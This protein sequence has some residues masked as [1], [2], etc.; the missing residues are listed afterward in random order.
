MPRKEYEERIDTLMTDQNTGS[1]PLPGNLAKMDRATTPRL[2]PTQV[3]YATHWVGDSDFPE[4]TIVG[5]FIA[6][7]A[8]FEMTLSYTMPDGTLEGSVHYESARRALEPYAEQLRHR[9]EGAGSALNWDSGTT[10][11]IKVDGF[12]MAGRA[13][14]REPYRLEY[15]FQWDVVFD[16]EPDLL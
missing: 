9:I 13:T 15:R 7:Q 8:R 12:R 4:S 1:A 14:K 5:P 11:V 6:T 3:L 10:H 2:S 16:E